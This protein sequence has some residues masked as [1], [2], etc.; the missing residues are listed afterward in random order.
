[1]HVYVPLS[2]RVKVKEAEA[3][4]RVEAIKHYR[5]FEEHLA[6]NEPAPVVERSA[7]AFRVTAS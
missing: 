7:G 4:D 2:Q 6:G 1:M 5:V 3:Y